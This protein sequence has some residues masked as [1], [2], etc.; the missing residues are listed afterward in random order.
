LT[1][2]TIHSAK[3]CEWDVVQILHAADGM[4][5]S[6]MAVGNEEGIEEERRLLYVAM[7][8]AKDRLYVNFPLRYYH[9]RFGLSDAHGYAQLTR[10]ISDT[11]RELFE[12]RTAGVEGDADDDDELDVASDAYTRVS[13]LWRE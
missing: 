8:R 4:I 5:P 13:R 12:L 1:L 7:T 6:D 2:S 11:N 3:G 10:F 9:R